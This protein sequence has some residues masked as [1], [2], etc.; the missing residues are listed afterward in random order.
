M[1]DN[2]YAAERRCRELM[3]IAGDFAWEIDA[4]SRFVFVAP[5][6]V[7]GWPADN[8]LGKPVSEFL[9]DPS[10]A[11][12]FAVT[13]PAQA[14]DIRFRAADGAPILLGLAARPV[15]GASGL[16]NGARG[17]CRVHGVQDL[18][19]A[20]R[21]IRDGLAGH[22]VRAVRDET[23]PESALN[24]A[25][26]ALGLASGAS[27][28]A[29]LRAGG[30]PP[31]KTAIS[32]G[33]KPPPTALLTIRQALKEK[34]SASAAGMASAASGHLAAH[35]VHYRHE[36]KGAVALW[37]RPEDRV[38]GEFERTL[39]GDVADRLGIVIAQIEARERIT[40]M[41]RTD[42][43]TTLTNRNAFFDE[44]ARRLLRLDRGT[45]SAVLLYIDVLNL[46]LVNDR[47]GPSS[48]DEA[49]VTLAGILRD[50]TR[51]GDLIA[52]YG[53][54]QF[55]LWIE[56]IS[57]EGA[58]RRVLAIETGARR[59]ASLTGDPE[60]PLRVAV[61]AASFD[62]L[63]PETPVQLVARSAAAAAEKHQQAFAQTPA[64][65]SA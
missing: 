53:G 18:T 20:D 5:R 42:P 28:G 37:R 48:G 45:Q 34:E 35:A 57:E 10:Q 7:F 23:Q 39:L 24:A 64:A 36:L 61:G 15:F 41:S 58:R 40:T 4:A 8:L 22:V 56:G 60:Q 38:F 12:L 54:S 46:K 31:L 65:R 51:A 44:F 30:D 29:I 16:W 33:I 14:G 62:P 27:G 2:A 49:L 26:V 52:R 43:L 32:W 3:E 11:R 50:N 47:H 19:Q 55:V 1:D 63:R 17:I 21:H 25:L 13:E 59:L 6:L 9:A